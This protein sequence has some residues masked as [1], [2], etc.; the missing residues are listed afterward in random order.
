M[1]VP[2]AMLAQPKRY[3]TGRHMA[4]FLESASVF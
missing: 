1:K 2:E 3:L 4:G